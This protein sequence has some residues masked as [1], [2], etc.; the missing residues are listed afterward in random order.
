MIDWCPYVIVLANNNYDGTGAPNWVVRKHPRTLFIQEITLQAGNDDPGVGNIQTVARLFV[1]NGDDEGVPTNNSL[2]DDLT[3]TAIIISANSAVTTFTF[4]L[5][6]WLPAGQRL[7]V[8]LGTAVAG[9]YYATAWGG[10]YSEA[11][12]DP[13]L[14][15]D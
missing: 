2:V 9:G 6:K 4:T 1:N 8:L 5:N 14:Y 12:G 13:E 10:Q 11:K 3:L 15:L 7:N